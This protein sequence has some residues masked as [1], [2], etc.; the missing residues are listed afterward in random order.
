MTHPTREDWMSYIYDELPL[1]S[2]S[3][4]QAHLDL[5]PACREQVEKWQRVSG[6]LDQY[7]LPRRKQPLPHAGIIR[8]AAAAAFVALAAVG[9]M[10]V[11]ALQ[12]EVTQLQS[13]MPGGLRREV[14]AAVRLEITSKMRAELE[15]ARAEANAQAARMAKAE[16]QAMIDTVSQRLEAQRVADKQTTFSVLQKLS[17][18]HA[19]DYAAL[20]KEL[21]T[22]AVLTEAG[23][24]RALNQIATLAYSPIND[25]DQN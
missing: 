8:W 16:A 14:E 7:R 6:S 12:R 5:C 4:I 15:A 24:Q 22:V 10:R 17:A 1:E 11:M 23:F 19:G 20:R 21:E 18:Q 13:A 2:R 9:A 25:S 3:A